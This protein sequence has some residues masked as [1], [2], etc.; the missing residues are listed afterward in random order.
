[1][2]G[3]K[4]RRAQ[5]ARSA[6]LDVAERHLASG[7][8]AAV[9]VQKV[10]E[11]L[12]LTDAAVHYHFGSR[13]K[14]MAALLRNAGR[15]LRAKF[16]EAPVAAAQTGV[17][18]VMMDQLDEIYRR[19]GYARLAMWLALDGWR[20]EGTGLHRPM[21]NRL[22]EARGAG[23]DAEETVLAVAAL[24]VFMMGDALAGEEMLAAAGLATDEESRRRLR[25]F[26]LDLLS[27]R[28][29]L[30]SERQDRPPAKAAKRRAKRDAGSG[31]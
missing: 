14:L 24:N 4:R 13:S 22:Q 20:A 6:I 10:A 3:T 17:L 1:M 25:G 8:P 2:S 26:F 27:A 30:A 23:A 7:G 11:E 15:K 21:A 18:A 16:E 5:D 31:P 19:K 9:R 12:G 28:L 29:G